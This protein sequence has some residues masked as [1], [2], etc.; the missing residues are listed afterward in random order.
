VRQ[1]RALLYRYDMPAN[2][3]NAISLLQ[4]SLAASPEHAPSYAAAAMAFYFKHGATREAHWS[5]QS[6]DSARRAVE[7]DDHLAAAHVALGLALSVTGDQQGAR[8]AYE[9]ALKLDP[10]NSDAHWNLGRL[11]SAKEPERARAELDEAIRIDPNH[12]AAYTSLG[13]LHY[14]REDLPAA[15][16]AWEHARKITPD[17]VLVLRNLSAVY[18]KL[19]R[20]DE[21]LAAIQSALEVQKLASLYSNLGVLQFYQARY[22]EAVD[23]FDR[24]IKQGAYF[25]G[26]WG[27][28]AD[29]Q[30]WSPAHKQ[31]APESYR[32]A[33]G[34]ARKDLA[35]KPDDDQVKSSLAVYLAKLGERDQA[36]EQVRTIRSSAPSVQFKVTVVYE[37]TGNRP[38]ALNALSSALSGKLP[39]SEVEREPELIALR[40]DPRYYRLV[41]GRR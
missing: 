14:G 23:A 19:G 28:L 15:L 7:L 4:A 13:T 25:Y 31:Q 16:A 6:L 1:A 18:D 17:N 36:L 27:N 3:D 39:Q 32:V 8:Q 20:N 41:H 10:R 37:L 21:A 24:A 33:V 22:P 5:R 40:T 30:R 38:A 29:A 9:R 2:V 11:L 35:K 34:L 12:W 26:T